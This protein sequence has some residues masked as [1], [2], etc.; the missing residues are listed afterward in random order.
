MG[1]RD[2]AVAATLGIVTALGDSVTHTSVSGV[3]RTI[4]AVFDRISEEA[5]VGLGI[6]GERTWIEVG[7]AEGEGIDIGDEIV[8]GAQTYVAVGID[9]D[10]HGLVTVMLE[11]ADVYE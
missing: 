3:S 10:R 5:A 7:S 6:D 8:V 4:T 9:Y 1:F 2:D 11:H